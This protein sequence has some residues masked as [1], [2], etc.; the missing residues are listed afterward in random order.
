MSAV[1]S[2]SI[3]APTLNIAGP[4]AQEF[5]A[6]VTAIIKLA[7]TDRTKPVLCSVLFTRNDDGCLRLVATD[8]HVLST[9]DT[10]IQVDAFPEFLLDAKD[11]TNAFKAIDKRARMFTFDQDGR[12]VKLS[13]GVSTVG[14]RTIDMQYPNIQV[15]LRDT[16]GDDVSPWLFNPKVMRRICQAAE[17]LG[18]QVVAYT[19]GQSSLKPQWFK[20]TAEA[21]VL[22]A[23]MMPVRR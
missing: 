20:A 16:A 4:G 9:I 15:L 23:I 14:L 18:D 7:S 8:S 2:E 12:N 22:T 21:G 1:M 19:G 10:P 6:V 13:D 11:L 5:R 17:A 3:P